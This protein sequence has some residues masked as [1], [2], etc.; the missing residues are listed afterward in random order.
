ML[1]EIPTKH[2]MLAWR[3]DEHRR[4]IVPARQNLPQALGADASEIR[5]GAAIA[6]TV[7]E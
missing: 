6:K 5:M 1:D 2:D 4:S 3:R 7:R